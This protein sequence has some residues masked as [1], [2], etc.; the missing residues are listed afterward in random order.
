MNLLLVASLLGPVAQMGEKPVVIGTHYTDALAGLAVYRDAKQ[1]VL[2][3]FGWTGKDGRPHQGYK[4]LVDAKVHFGEAAPDDSY[5][6]ISW[7][8]GSATITYEWGRV[9]KDGAVGRLTSTGAV[10]IKPSL[11]AAWPGSKP[12]AV[13]S[14]HGVTLFADTLAVSFDADWRI[15]PSS[16]EA[17]AWAD[18]YQIDAKTPLQFAIGTG[19]LANPR[20]AGAIL[21]KARKKY[22]TGRL[23]AEGDW[24]DFL[25]PFENQLGNTKIYSVESGRLAHIV[26]RGWCLPDGQVLFCWD[27]FF[28]GLLSSFEDPKGARQTLRA[29]LAETTK[30]GFV[31][32][33]AGRGWGVSVDRSQPPVGSY[34]IWKIHQ[35]DPDIAFLK[36][37]YPKLLRWHNWWFGSPSDANLPNRDGNGNGLLEWGSTTGDLQ[38]AKYES[39]LDDSPM[40]DDGTMQGKNMNLDS[41]DLSALWAMDAEYLSRIA[42]AIGKKADA[43][44]LRKERQKMAQRMDRLL[45]NEAIGAYCYR[46][47]T[48]KKATEEL[49]ASSV[50]SESGKSGFKGEYYQ[51]RE[52]Q[53]EPS[54]RQD[55]DINFDWAKGPMSGFGPFN[56]SVRWTADFTT[57]KA[58]PYMFEV[59]SDDGC[60]LWIDD[61][62][63]VD[64]WTIHGSTKYETPYLP[65]KAGEKHRIRMEYFQAE[66]GAS[67]SLK[68][69]RV[70]EEKP[71]SV[72]YSRLSPLNFY[73]LIVDA[74][75]QKRARRTLDLFFRPDQF[76][77]KYVC[78]TISKSDPAYPA[79]GYWRGTVWGPTSYLTF[80]GLRRYATGAEMANYAEKSV[81]LFMKNWNEDGSCHENFNSI[82]GWGRSDP[83]YTWGELLCLVGLEELCDTDADGRVVLNGASGKHIK[84]H[85]LRIGGRLFDL[86]VE[87][88]RATLSQNGKVV[89][90]AVGKVERVKI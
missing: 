28:N 21:A 25:S 83:H 56:Y 78:P 63:V 4:D 72:F 1:S 79:Q 34:C 13:A 77:G 59:Q 40:F 7:S 54:I 26:S 17:G 68:V 6:R 18:R 85:N 57:P 66:G 42:D 33:Y 51:G 88:K 45:W 75:S 81:A 89:G 5:H 84:V 69:R 15:M 50:F 39:G 16:V 47:W 64:A 90:I 60:R 55:A 9:G 22:K 12:H 32:N 41:T 71:A 11:G 8:A 19:K 80:Q 67:A 49:K 44:V 46:Y 3:N 20:D 86:K 36:E 76:G 74:P 73:P 58:G 10:E 24:G 43:I 52:L 37:V 82:T 35:R 14:G 23:W 53:G 29:I 30:E 70:V 65:F 87:P 61:K 38:N 27:S 2:L 31:P 62:K 48:P